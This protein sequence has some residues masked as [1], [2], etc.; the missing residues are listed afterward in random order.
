MTS[1]ALGLVEG[2]VSRYLN[3]PVSRRVARVL[4]PTPVTPNQVSFVSL[5]VAVASLPLFIADIP[6]AAALAIHASSVIDGVDGDLARR[7]GTSSRIGAI[8]D[9]TLDRFADATIFLGMALWCADSTAQPSPLELGLAATAAA[10]TVSYSRARIEASA[11]GAAGAAAGLATRD[12]RLFVAAL[13]SAVGL[14]YWALALIAAS[15]AATVAYR[16][17]WLQRRLGGDVAGP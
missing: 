5:L 7:Q 11:P 4:A 9:A 10:L 2:P 16:M 12:V 3:R 15:G 13:L 8:F 1:G 14:A 6:I 17:L